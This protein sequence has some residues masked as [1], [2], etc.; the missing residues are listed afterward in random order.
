MPLIRT[1]LLL[2]GLCGAVGASA[3]PA[4]F[5]APDADAGLL[6]AD[7]AFQLLPASRRAQ[8]LKIEWNISPGYYLYRGQLTFEVLA[9]QG[10]RLAP[11]QLPA[12]EQRQDP[13]F[14][15][16]EVYR[17]I[18]GAEFLLPPGLKAPLKLR[19]RYQGCADIG[20][21]YPPQSQILDVPAARS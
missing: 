16:V 17:G 11:P 20:I 5:G 8:T 12:G 18:L 21:C 9:P 7:E 2:L 3:R 6:P 13:E 15:A 1:L 4:I 14:G 19:V 10:F